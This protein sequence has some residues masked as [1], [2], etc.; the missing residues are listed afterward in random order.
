M[1]TAQDIREKG[2]E[3]AK[4]NGYAKAEVDDFLEEIAAEVTNMQKE[5]AVL[6]S[7]MK[8]LVDKIE[9]YRSNEEALNLALLSA[10]K[11]AVQIESEARTRAAAMI[12]DADK[13]V[14]AKIGSISELADAEE[15][16]LANAKAS[17]QKFFDA[18][19]TM[20]NAQLKKIDTLANTY[21][22][23]AA[24][25][26][27]AAEPAVQAAPQPAPAA[28]VDA[29]VRSIENSVSKIKPEPEFKIDLSSAIESV[30]GSK[31]SFDSTQ[32][33]TF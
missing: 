29:T 9:E 18:M 22:V 12:S 4:I 31:K 33:F 15:Q 3:T 21:A 32:P 2:F 6:K 16:R 13:Q 30:N 14:S 26:A 28:S 17:N 1:I 23:P 20:C 8:V 10:Q 25:A 7:K 19:R 24:A 5:N 11:L 27:P